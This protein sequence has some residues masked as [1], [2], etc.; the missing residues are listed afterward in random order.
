MSDGRETCAFPGVEKSVNAV[1]AVERN[2]EGVG[3]QDAVEV[4]EG[5]ED[6]FLRLSFAIV[7]PVRSL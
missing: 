2:A 7:R 5:A 6:A 3:L 1:P 4:V